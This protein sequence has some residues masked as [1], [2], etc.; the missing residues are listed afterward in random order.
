[1]F[2]R[3]GCLMHH[4]IPCYEW[5]HVINVLSLFLCRKDW[6]INTMQQ[7]E[8]GKTKAASASGPEH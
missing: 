2:T 6:E 5:K 4:V 7:K 3:Q 1:M 8:H